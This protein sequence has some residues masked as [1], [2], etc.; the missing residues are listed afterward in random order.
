MHLCTGI[1]PHLTDSRRESA[2]AA[3]GD[4]TV[5]LPVARLQQCV[6]DFLLHDGVAYLDDAAEAF[7]GIVQFSGG[8]RCAVDAIAPGLPTDGDDEVS[9]FN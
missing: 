4:G 5:E 6:N 8:E 3:I 1:L 9:R 7:R 2:C